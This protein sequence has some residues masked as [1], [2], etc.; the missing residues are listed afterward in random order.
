MTSNSVLTPALV[1]GAAALATHSQRPP[2]PTAAATKVA[3]ID[4]QAAILNSQE[5][6][7]AVTGLRSQFEPRRAQQQRQQE[8]QALQ[9]RLSKGSAAMSDAAKERLAAGIQSKTR[10]LKRDA[11]DLDAEAT[12]AQNKHGGSN[13][14][15]E[16]LGPKMYAVVDKYASQRGYHVVLNAGHPQAPVYW[17]DSSA[18]ITGDLVK[19]YDVAH[20]P[21]AAAGDKK[22]S[23]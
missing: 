9:D 8:L 21:K 4:I 5:G 15:G 20:P 7:Q 13:K 19:Q 6:Q 18:V 11:E 2:A 22:P 14:M 17:A 23:H 1:V 12:E 10:I 16:Q 3:I